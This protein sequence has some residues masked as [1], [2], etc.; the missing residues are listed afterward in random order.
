VDAPAELT[1][2]ECNCSICA[3]SGYLHLI[4]PRSRFR[5]LQGSES[6]TTYTFNTGTAKHL[7]CSVCGVKS[8]YV[9][10]S[11][12]DGYSVNVHCLDPSTIERI[13]IKPFNGLEWEKQYPE[14]RGKLPDD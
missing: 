2:S 11:H 14:G 13:E 4:V 7:F 3:K 9:P 6:L 1:A 5:L 10:R 12:P 8:F